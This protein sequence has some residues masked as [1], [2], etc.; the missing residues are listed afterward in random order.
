[1]TIVLEILYSKTHVEGAY[2]AAETLTPLEENAK[3]QMKEK[4][5]VLDRRSTVKPFW[6]TY[7]SEACE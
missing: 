2:R 3:T 4:M 1:M 5:E 6:T 7:T